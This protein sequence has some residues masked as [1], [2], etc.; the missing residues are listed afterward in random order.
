MLFQESRNTSEET[1]EKWNKVLNEVFKIKNKNEDMI[2]IGDT[3]ANVGKYVKEN[4]AKTSIGG[5]I[6][7]DLVSTNDFELVN[8]LDCLVNG[9][10]TRVD[11][12]DPE[13]KEKLSLLDRT[14]SKL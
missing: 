13:K 3:N 10:F 11:P 9:P 4:H 6:L 1:T 14:F 12:S 8:S 7:I 5:K 2:L